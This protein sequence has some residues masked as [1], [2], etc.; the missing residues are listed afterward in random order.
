MSCTRCM[1]SVFKQDTKRLKDKETTLFRFFGD[2]PVRKQPGGKALD[3]LY[4]HE[5]KW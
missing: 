1:Q 3:G 2:V 5:A 4:L